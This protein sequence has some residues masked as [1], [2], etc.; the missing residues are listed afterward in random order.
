ML[1][2]FGA[3]G[4][5]SSE[6]WTASGS[7]VLT[8]LRNLML[9]AGIA[10]GSKSG[11]WTPGA[12]VKV[13]R[14]AILLS[15]ASLVFTAQSATFPAPQFTGD[16]N[17]MGRGV[18][19]VMN[20]LSSSTREHRNT[21]RVLFYGQSITEQNWWKLIADDLRRQYPEAN[22]IIE[23][24]AIGG[25]AAQLLVKTAEADLYPFYPDLLIFH[26]YGSHLEYE[27][28]IRRVRERTTAEIVM[29]TDHMTQDQDLTEETDPEKLTPKNWNAFMNH[30]FLPQ[31]AAKYGAELADLRTAWGRY[32]LDHQLS[33]TNL[34]RDG[35]HLNDHGC[36]VMAELLKPWLRLN[37]AVDDHAWTNWVRTFQLGKELVPRGDRLSCDFTGN[38]LDVIIASTVTDSAPIEVWID[39]RR[40]SAIASLRTFSRVSAFPD[41]NWPCLLQIQSAAALEVEDWTLTVTEAS[42][43]LKTVKFT[44]AGSKTGDDG[45]G[46]STNR[47]V[48]TSKRVVIEPGDWNLGYCRQVFKRTIEPG[49]KITWKVVPWFRDEFRPEAGADAAIQ[50]TVT[51]AQGLAN[52]PHHLELRGR[53]LASVSALR[54]YCPPGIAIASSASSAQPEK[55]K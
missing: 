30:R 1:L 39:G 13:M 2:R 49:Y 15:I 51:L 47:F 11:N 22:L 25:H 5:S 3:D 19:R 24:R 38:R 20:L 32:L 41:S 18:Q 7:S 46:V 52:A 4:G 54:V 12:V 45:Q 26:V 16:T 34:L 27:N 40:P 36:F 55:S 33:A 35:V 42:D 10:S 8:Y 48:S 9:P 6:V 28:I 17:Q 53:N 21:V 44:V 14:A 50:T 29:Q 23:N 37:P 31:T 43:D